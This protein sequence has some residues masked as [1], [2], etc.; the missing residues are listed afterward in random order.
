MIN[1][2][3]GLFIIIGVFFGILKGKVSSINTVMF[4]SVK[5]SLDMIIN[6]I[7]IMALWL[8]IM[9]IA[10]K[11]G[12][13]NKMAKLISPV[14]SK[15]FPEL[16]KNHESLSLIASNVIMNIFGLGNAAT[17]FGIKAMDE[18]Q[19]LNKNK[20][21]AT[22]SMI[23]FLVLNTSGVTIIP[24]SIIAIRIMHG[25]INPTSITLICIL[26]TLISTISG[27]TMDR[28]LGRLNHD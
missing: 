17:P 23:T 16:P 26:S 14:L 8:G 6:L 11:S 12:L 21:I 5:A 2:I 22:R 20:N 28:I 24:T 10:K 19:K 9:N 4:T 18:M 1:Y 7:P 27:L 13:L 25:S 15:I 3:W